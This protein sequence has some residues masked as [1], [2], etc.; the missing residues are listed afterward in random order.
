VS[1][2]DRT[3]FEDYRQCVLQIARTTK[4]QAN[5]NSVL[6]LAEGDCRDARLA[7]GLEMTADDLEKADDLAAPSNSDVRMARLTD[8]LVEEVRLLWQGDKK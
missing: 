4:S 6:T 5:P 7:A 8:E 1:Q 2:S 3:S